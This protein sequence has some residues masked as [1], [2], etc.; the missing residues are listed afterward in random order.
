M[1]C[2]GANLPG[3]KSIT[4]EQPSPAQALRNSQASSASL[5]YLSGVAAHLA[6]DALPGRQLTWL[7][8]FFKRYWY[9]QSGYVAH[10]QQDTGLSLT[11]L[12]GALRALNA[13]DYR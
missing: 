7:Q 3:E 13:A 5:G 2:S 9:L 1:C 10:Q 12:P 6:V 8:Q 11:V 4:F